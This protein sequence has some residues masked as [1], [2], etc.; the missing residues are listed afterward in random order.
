MHQHFI[1]RTD[2]ALLN[3][4]LRVTA[5][6]KYTMHWNWAVV[7]WSSASLLLFPSHLLHKHSSTPHTPSYFNNNLATQQNSRP[8][9]YDQNNSQNKKHSLCFSGSTLAKRLWIKNI[10]SKR[11]SSHASSAHEGWSADSTST[12]TKLKQLKSREFLDFLR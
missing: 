4:T 3:L 10:D 5:K 6:R 2:L 8:E 9:I 11:N 1:K 7:N 12:E